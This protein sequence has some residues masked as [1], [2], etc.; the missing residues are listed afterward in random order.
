MMSAVGQ[1]VHPPANHRLCFLLVEKDEAGLSPR[2]LLIESAKHNVITAYTP[3]EGVEMF[4]RFENVDAVALDAQFGDDQCAEAA[5]SIKKHHPQVRIVAFM[6]TKDHQCQWADYR[7]E[8]HHPKS[9]LDMLVKM[10][11]STNIA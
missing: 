5:A 1:T 6:S 10:G 7:V 9:L 4:Q 11:G 2:K 3:D 8:P